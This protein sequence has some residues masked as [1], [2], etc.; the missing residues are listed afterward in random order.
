MT[1]TPIAPRL[2][3]Q[4]KVRTP[5][6]DENLH[7]RDRK[8]RFIETGA[9]VRIW[10]GQT[11]T[12]ERNVGGGK[13]E[14]LRADGKKVI[15]H[16]NYLTVIAAP[17]GKAPETDPAKAPD[18]PVEEA[19]PDA[20]EVP[21][22]A[23]GEDIA[24]PERGDA[25][26]ILVEDV[27]PGEQVGDFTVGEY[28]DGP[29]AIDGW[30]V[31][32]TP[33]GGPIIRTE[34]GQDWPLLPDAEMVRDP[35]GPE[36]PEQGQAAAPAPEG[37]DAP[38]QGQ[39]APEA[40]TQAPEAP[41]GGE[42][43][44]AAP[45]ARDLTALDD[46]EL[47]VVANEASQRA[48]SAQTVDE[49][50]AAIADMRAASNEYARRRAAAERGEQATPEGRD[51]PARSVEPE[52]PD[53][54]AE[55]AP[56]ADA[57]AREQSIAD[58]LNDPAAQRARLGTTDEP[59]LDADEVSA[60]RQREAQERV[61][62][63]QPSNLDDAM[64]ERDRAREAVLARIG[65]DYVPQGS[66]RE[67]GADIIAG[68][69]GDD[70]ADRYI[71]GEDMTA[72]DYRYLAMQ[73]EAARDLAGDNAT[74]DHDGLVEDFYSRAGDED[75]VNREGAIGAP[76]AAP[77]AD[78]A[79]DNGV[80]ALMS[81]PD[82]T[83]EQQVRDL[84][85]AQVAEGRAGG[86]EYV[87]AVVGESG[88]RIYLD[89]GETQAFNTEDMADGP[90]PPRPQPET[91][92]RQRMLDALAA[93]QVEEGVDSAQAARYA[94][95]ASMIRNGTLDDAQSRTIL[96]SLA[97]SGVPGSQSLRDGLADPEPANA[98]EAPS[99]PEVDPIDAKVQQSFD[100]GYRAYMDNAM[101]APSAE[102]MN[103]IDPDAPVGDEGN[104][105]IMVAFGQ[106][107]DRAIDDDLAGSLMPPDLVEDDE[108][109]DLP[110]GAIGASASKGRTT[111]YTHPDG[112]VETRS[113]KGR[114]YSHVVVSH[115]ATPEARK[116]AFE[117][118]AV[119]LEKTADLLD[120]AADAGVV[121]VRNRN[122][123]G[124]DRGP[125]YF[126]SHEVF[127]DGTQ[128]TADD[129][130][131]TRY[132]LVQDR[133]NGDGEVQSYYSAAPEGLTVLREVDGNP[134]YGAR[135]YLIA[136]ARQ[137][138]AGNRERA[139]SLRED[140]SKP[141][142]HGPSVLRWTSSAN[143]GRNAA[144]GEF[145][146][147]T[148]TYGRTVTVEPVDED[149]DEV[150]IDPEKE[151]L[152]AMQAQAV[153]NAGLDPSR[154][155]VQGNIFTSTAASIRQGDVVWTLGAGTEA[156][157]VRL[158]PTRG[159]N[160]APNAIARTFTGTKY[161]SDPRGSRYAG[162][163]VWTFDDG[164]STGT[165]GGSVI[166]ERI[167]GGTRVA[168]VPERDRPAPEPEGGDQ[169][170]PEADAEKAVFADPADGDMV[171]I[172]VP[173]ANG[174]NHNIFT[175]REETGR[176]H[177]GTIDVNGRSEQE[178]WD[179]YVRVR[180]N[181]GAT[182]RKGDA[183]GPFGNGR[184][185]PGGRGPEPAPGPDPEPEPVQPPA[186]APLPANPREAADYV[187]ALI[188]DPEVRDAVQAYLN[189]TTRAVNGMYGSDGLRMIERHPDAERLLPIVLTARAGVVSRRAGE[190]GPTRR[191][192]GEAAQAALNRLA[193]G[194]PTLPAN[195]VG[196][197][198]SIEV[199]DM[200]APMRFGQ[201]AATKRVEGEVVGISESTGG[202]YVRI[203]DD[204]GEPH[205]QSMRSDAVVDIRPDRE[206]DPVDPNHPAA[207]ISNGAPE[208]IETAYVRN[209]DSLGRDVGPTDFAR[210]VEPAGRYMNIVDSDW[211]V[212]NAAER[213]WQTGR[214]RFEKPLHMDFGGQYD[215]ESNW[216]RRL[217]AH[218][219]GL[220]GQALSDAVR[221]D[222][223]DAI[224]TNDRYGDSEVVDLSNGAAEVTP[225][226]GGDTG[227]TVDPGPTPP[228]P[229]PAP[230][231]P[232]PDEDPE[233]FLRA[234]VTPLPDMNADMDEYETD[235]ELRLAIK[236]ID[237]NLVTLG[238]DEQRQALIYRARLVGE[239]Q[240]R[241]AEV[242]PSPDPNPGAEVE[243][244]TVSAADIEVGVR[245]V[246][247]D[248][249]MVT[250]EDIDFEDDEYEFTYVDADGNRGSYFATAE[251]VFTVVRGDS[252]VEPTPPAPEQN[253]DPGVDRQQQV[254]G[255]NVLAG[256]R[257]WLGTD[258]VEVTEVVP[259][260]ADTVRI[261]VRYADR[262]TETFPFGRE[263]V[264][265]RADDQF[266]PDPSPLDAETRTS[267]PVLYTY[268]RRNIVAL[269]L[270]TDSD[271]MVAEAARRIRLRQPLAAAHSAA[272]AQRLT[273]MASADGVKP[274]RQRM[275]LRLAA[276]NNAASI[277]AGGRGVD[278]PDMP[279]ADSVTKGRPSDAGI[280][281]QIA[282][283]GLNGVLVQGRVTESRTMMSGRL[284]QVTV[285]GPDGES[286]TVMLTRNSD[287]YVLPDLP[288]PV[289]VPQPAGAN[290]PEMVD[291][292]LLRPGD[293]IRIP[294]TYDV[295]DEDQRAEAVILR[296]G[297]EPSGNTYAVLDVRAYSS[298]EDGQNMVLTSIPGQSGYEAF[299]IRV[300]RGDESADQPRLTDLPP[301]NEEEVNASEV[302]LGDWMVTRIGSRG[303]AQT[304]GI[305]VAVET[306]NDED[307]NRIGQRFN[308]RSMS[309][310]GNWVT[311]TDAEDYTMTRLIKGDENTVLRLA[312]QK[313]E[314]ERHAARA[315]IVA[316]VEST[317]SD[318]NRDL[319][320]YVAQNALR[321]G[322]DLDDRFYD[323]TIA[324]VFD[325]SSDPF[326]TAR[327]RAGARLAR[328][329]QRHI[330][331][332]SEGPEFTAARDAAMRLADQII[333]D[334]NLR[335]RM[336]M[337]AVQPTQP[338]ET[339]VMAGANLARRLSAGSESVEQRDLVRI[340]QTVVE[341]REA[342]EAAN[343][344]EGA[345]RDLTV[346]DLPEGASLRDRMAA[347]KSRMSSR[348]G[349]NDTEVAA[350]GEFTLDSLERGEVPEIVTT[351]TRSK[352]KAPD[353]GP[354]AK[355]MADLDVVKA[356][357]ADLDREITRRVA[358]AV[359]D[360][361]LTD[362]ARAA[363]LT[364]DDLTAADFERHIET[365]NNEKTVLYNRYR[366]S[367][368]E[369][370]AL[371]KTV[372][373]RLAQEEGYADFDALTES[374]YGA[375]YT[376]EMRELRNR[377]I[378][379]TR[380]S[381][382]V[383]EFDE[384]SAEMLSEYRSY[385]ERIKA[386]SD[387]LA[388]ARA[389][390]ARA[391]IAEVREM[392]GKEL[393]YN[394]AGRR[395]YETTSNPLRNGETMRAMR[396]AE[397]NYPREWLDTL[398]A[399]PKGAISIGSS[400]RGFFEGSNWIIRLSKDDNRNNTS[401]WV[402]PRGRVATHELGHAMETVIPG[403]SQA[404]EAFLWSRTSTGEVGQRERTKRKRIDS[405]T[406]Y[407]DEFPEA[408]SGKDYADGT[409]YELFT[410]GMESMFAGSPYLDEDFRNW[411][412]GT[413]ALL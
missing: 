376:T 346:P 246:L 372:Q 127:L 215:E 13:I 240:R 10:G 367:S 187:A 313:R 305:V 283:L 396:Y 219:G 20:E 209:P 97:A 158:M 77:A 177:Q 370:N 172:S 111:R 134:V 353:G 301:F 411:L 232:D 185:L 171:T 319:S 264:L 93:A 52:T 29:S 116:A 325:G 373:N 236:G 393:R 324:D 216:K 269:G 289:V 199:L 59:S 290:V 265:D 312:E 153:T 90:L 200:D 225:D 53:Q 196:H 146:Y 334:H 40:A 113:S 206:P 56:E 315:Q 139:A 266:L 3:M 174:I 296:T 72:D 304:Q 91:P 375:G 331:G 195:S 261:T 41:G 282:F 242:E 98:P 78:A 352:D 287:V 214:V 32:A 382:E 300:S 150:V 277:E 205:V 361:I 202:V 163:R 234:L 125:D 292:S 137:R 141:D 401:G 178:V 70:V 230:V 328:D 188:G 157:P 191:W 119:A 297:V 276:A 257:L 75:D 7:P 220:A 25:P 121:K 145:S 359:G 15:V 148:E 152:A 24:L 118:Q 68:M 17:G 165:E 262:R 69:I 14:V 268:Q 128:I 38:E 35:N 274:Q 19:S 131:R 186:G 256:D 347:Y 389:E 249:S 101:R 368:T 245:V 345:S 398:D 326:D 83:S 103:L 253:P 233:G 193:S 364:T 252:G 194:D 403:L 81:S 5:D 351:T 379:S 16:R 391:V 279:N 76:P 336:A 339:R 151:R 109:D 307:G 244:D 380:T 207:A 356:A 321:N 183:P 94:S 365:M 181:N 11:G 100:L 317:L 310:S 258:K 86:A 102:A 322:V 87:D 250:I 227:S 27:T 173:G 61:D 46:S 299:A 280:G 9:E 251:S 99:V 123:G 96:D 79:V 33:Q 344:P 259:Q 394:T 212:G 54:V 108:D 192:D 80:A 243:T 208:P 342:R 42:Q 306:I 340:A 60:Q 355:A 23:D 406:S 104:R 386:L 392:G 211:A 117:R 115:P 126:H 160:K 182:I 272:L 263:A 161:Q 410:T 371:Y 180:D 58:R 8:G 12:V 71:A 201:P 260:D 330:S 140:G 374:M 228:P 105:R 273:D 354:G 341:A 348:F 130:S 320:F 169:T 213:G 138:A 162:A 65:D 363:G 235:D 332:A 349:F 167:A 66:A 377:I 34:E 385:D 413:L 92:E 270:D 286:R 402:P 159:G 18:V 124:G 143:L 26:D 275:L 254:L 358:A 388:K 179:A 189:P 238:P 89:N 338:G 295:F 45:Q 39:D 311:V 383:V 395:N 132:P 378:A 122:L 110:D 298:N 48:D 63:R 399:S 293:R 190:R 144:S 31:G 114:T 203:I 133:A 142:P 88:V 204:S 231:V 255:G 362:D 120:A 303:N 247:D 412:L 67:L 154:I 170:P 135:E 30:V 222:G 318:Y 337:Q 6:F 327:V 302:G 184:T 74:D 309:G 136:T 278:I 37:Q 84:V 166:P 2:Q 217:S 271:P 64:A 36:M 237:D 308:L 164:T 357:G 333:A 350:F 55:V 95:M 51:E 387:R 129:R 285:E 343:L 294:N 360:E 405:S 147:E 47:D 50:R 198:A 407:V 155:K 106:G 409:H 229:G 397:T 369:R 291:V 323:Q 314:R 175:Y 22:L 49:A 408:Y 21:E 168:H 316:T 281:D 381:P 4:F 57:A 241:Q 107:Y 149:V 384:R 62:A 210:D 218:Y 197:R 239:R 226:R 390:A 221:A 366:D 176:W 284:T 288:E 267:R 329:L 85:S 223:Y 224:I 400:K 404:E 112:T 248:G 335:T 1:S 82:A 44:A 156:D 28:I 73:F 43:P